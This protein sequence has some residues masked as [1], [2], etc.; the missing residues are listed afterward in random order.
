MAVT[1]PQRDALSEHYLVVFPAT[2][3]RESL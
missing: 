3:L 2:A 1:I